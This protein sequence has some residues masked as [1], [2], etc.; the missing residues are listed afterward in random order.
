MFDQSVAP[1]AVRHA[2]RRIVLASVAL[3]AGVA[4]AA[5]AQGPAFECS[6]NSAQSSATW[7][8]SLTAPFQTGTNPATNRPFSY[9]IGTWDPASNP[10]GTR[11]LTGFVGDPGTSVPI[12][13][14]SGGLN[15]SGQS[16]AT[17][18][19]PSGTWIFR[20]RGSSI[21][22]EDL[23]INL[24][25]EDTISAAASVSI[26]YA[27]FRTRQPTCTLIGGFPI[28][29]PLG[30]V[31]VNTL[32]VNQATPSS[33]GTLTPTGPNSYSFSI[34][35][36]IVATAAATFQGAPIELTPFPA[37]VVLEGTLV[38]TGD[39]AAISSTLNVAINQVQPGPTPLD[40]IPFTEPLCSGSLLVNVTLANQTVAV[41]ANSTLV[42]SGTRTCAYDYNQD[43]NADLTDAQLLAQVVVGLRTADPAW[44][45][46]DYNGDENVDVTDAQQVAAA[47][48]SGTC[49]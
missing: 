3:L 15:A 27:S 1:V 23:S 29:V 41:G 49:P 48:V 44:L 11:T 21:Q 10:T 45:D 34:P 47:V 28:S 8:A 24:L 18:L 5:V 13:I 26:T 25:D 42:A 30:E 38:Q 2:A 12:N 33:S 39:T 4:P 6:L 9:L 7:N 37:A 17:P 43:E 31:V 20:L 35:V 19:R 14:S 36:P 22:V 46:G 40:P 32:I 16:G